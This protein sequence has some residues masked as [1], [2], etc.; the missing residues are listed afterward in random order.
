MLFL[1]LLDYINFELYRILT[2]EKL[3]NEEKY[4]PSGFILDQ[5]D[6]Q[7][8]AP[9][10]GNSYSKT[11]GGSTITKDIHLSYDKVSISSVVPKSVY[12]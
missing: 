7:E 4:P 9:S 10:L 5:F 6:H 1:N 12:L 2:T 8:L 3:Q 11:K